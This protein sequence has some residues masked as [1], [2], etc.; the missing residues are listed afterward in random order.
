MLKIGDRVRVTIDVPA[1]M[2]EGSPNLKGEE[3][4]VTQNLG[5]ANEFAAMIEGI[6]TGTDRVLV[7]L[8]NIEQK[9][10]LPDDPEYAQGAF[11]FG[12]DEIE[13]AEAVAEAA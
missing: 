9:N 12:S 3:G 13:L 2:V 11:L 7:K 1:D 4:T 10:N 6:T 5:P 8:D